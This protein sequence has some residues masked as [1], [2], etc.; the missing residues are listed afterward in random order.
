MNVNTMKVNW[1][2][3]NH[4]VVTET[5]NYMDIQDASRYFVQNSRLFKNLN[6][7]HT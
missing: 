4:T 5:V 7:K 3:T 2:W 6:L 1:K